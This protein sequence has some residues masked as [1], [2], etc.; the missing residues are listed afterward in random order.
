MKFS[1]YFYDFLFITGFRQFDYYVPSTLGLLRFLD[2]WVYSC[3]Q[4]CNFFSVII[5]SN[6]FSV[7]PSILVYGA[8][9]TSTEWLKQNKFI[10]PQFWSLEVRLK[11]QQLWPI[12]SHCSLSSPGLSSICVY[13]QISSSSIKTSVIL[14]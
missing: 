1:G 5:S 9:I 2:L 7:S 4:I 13:V 12:N 10:F 8:A 11:C 14:D 3:Q 6:I